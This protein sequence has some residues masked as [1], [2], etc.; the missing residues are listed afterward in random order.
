MDRAEIKALV[1]EFDKRPRRDE[2]AVWLLFTRAN[3]F[4]IAVDVDE[5][6]VEPNWQAQLAAILR[7]VRATGLVVAIPRAD[8]RPT[9]ADLALWRVVQVVMTRSRISPLDLVV[10]G[11]HGFWSATVDGGTRDAAA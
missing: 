8:G 9:S 7:A 4:L 2:G 10:V 1:A 6:T 3:G 11:E 5:A